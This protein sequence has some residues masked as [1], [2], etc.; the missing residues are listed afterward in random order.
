MI[1]KYVGLSRETI[2]D[3]CSTSTLHLFCSW[4]V[5]KIVKNKFYN[6]FLGFCV[7]F[8]V[9]GRFLLILEPDSIF[10]LSR[11][12]YDRLFHIPLLGCFYA[13][14]LV[15]V[16]FRFIMIKYSD[17]GLVEKG[18]I[19]TLMNK[20]YYLT[21]LFFFCFDDKIFLSFWAKT[22]I[23]ELI[24]KGIIKEMW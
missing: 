11:C 8:V 10:L 23:I 3:P 1:L 19:R 13:W 7:P 22:F 18:I 24:M 2:M 17:R 9:G 21:N 12:R 4:M 20:L 6:I 15:S 5:C 16:G 14:G